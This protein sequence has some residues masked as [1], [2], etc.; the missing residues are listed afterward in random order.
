MKLAKTEKALIRDT[1]RQLKAIRKMLSAKIKA[2]ETA[3]GNAPNCIKGAEADDLL[4]RL[5]E[6]DLDLEFA[7][8]SMAKLVAAKTAAKAGKE[9]GGA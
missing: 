8:E 7:V 6:A 2:C 3:R 4:D 5:I 9:G 1:A